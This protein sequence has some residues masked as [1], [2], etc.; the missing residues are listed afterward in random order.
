M[1]SCNTFMQMRFLQQRLTINFHDTFSQYFS[2]ILFHSTFIQYKHFFTRLF[3][4]L[5]LRYFL[6]TCTLFPAIIPYL[7]LQCFFRNDIFH[8]PFTIRESQPYNSRLPGPRVRATSSWKDFEAGEWEASSFRPFSF[9]L[10]LLFSCL[11][12]SRCALR[13]NHS[14]RPV[15]MGEV[16]GVRTA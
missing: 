6:A 8:K 13:L 15:R 11:R 3:Y 4:I 7:F 12:Y 1:L 9:S 10:F 14:T 5:F 2:T 16:R